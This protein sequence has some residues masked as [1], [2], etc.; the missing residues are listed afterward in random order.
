[1]KKAQ[2]ASVI[3]LCE[4]KIT[5]EDADIRVVALRGLSRRFSIRG[6]LRLPGNISIRRWN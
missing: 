1:M 3:A 5:D 2:F 6:I 4:L